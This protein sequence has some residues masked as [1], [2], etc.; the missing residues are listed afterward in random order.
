MNCEYVIKELTKEDFDDDFNGFLETLRNLS[1]TGQISL[2]EMKDILSKINLQGGSIYIAKTRE[3]K[4]IG[5]VKLIIEQKFIHNGGRVG[6]IEDVAIMKEFEGKGIASEI[7][8]RIISLARQNGCY[9]II[10]D[11]NDKLTSFYQK[12]GF[13]KN[14]NC[15]RLDL[16]S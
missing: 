12:F 6:H 13:Y 9:K 14:E 8:K 15:M 16:I 7:I 2:K 10:L 4:I 5:T 11:C 3:G 1:E